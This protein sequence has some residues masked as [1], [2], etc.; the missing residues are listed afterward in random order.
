[1]FQTDHKVRKDKEE[2]RDKLRDKERII[3]TDKDTHK[4]YNY[5]GNKFFGNLGRI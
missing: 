2:E 3:G 1:M 4:F 5:M